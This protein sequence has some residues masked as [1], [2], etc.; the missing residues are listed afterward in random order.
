MHVT[1]FLQLF[2]SYSFIK[3]FFFVHN[4]RDSYFFQLIVNF[5]CISSSRLWICVALSWTKARNSVLFRQF[6]VRILRILK[7][8]EVFLDWFLIENWILNEYLGFGKW[9]GW[10]L[11][12]RGF[13]RYPNGSKRL[14]E[15]PKRFFP[16]VKIEFS[17]SKPQT[18]SR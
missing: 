10:N 7:N 16:K 1:F 15:I 8:G 5:Y 2:F 13:K 6:F 11:Y 12:S 9:K 4:T 3:I 17:I 18:L 14:Q